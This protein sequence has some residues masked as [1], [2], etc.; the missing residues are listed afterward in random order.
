MQLRSS[1]APAAILALLAWAH[2][3]I[4]ATSN[5][6]ARPSFH[7]S[8]TGSGRPMILI[9]GLASSGETYNGV[10]AHYAGHYECHVLTLAGFAGE[11]RIEAPFLE[12]VR[13]DLARYIRDSHLDKPVIVGHSLGGF[14]AL[15]L[16]ETYPDLT[17]P[18]I[19][20][21]SLPFLP[22]VFQQG[23]T[24]ENVRPQAEMM[25]KAMTTGSEQ[26]RRKSSEMA[27]RSM[28]TSDANYQMVLGWGL[29]SDPVAVGNAMYDLFVHDLRTDT[30][31]V[32]SPVLVIGTWI[33]LKDY[34]TRDAVEKNFHAQYAGVKD[35]RFVMAEKARHFVM[36]DDPEWFLQQTDSFLEA[37]K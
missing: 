1:F 30:A 25:R 15:W 33:G 36:L 9:P 3:L 32:T 13:D 27:I 21:D 14:L 29:Q 2:P 28:V 18:V 8:V 16:A 11:P 37:H 23:A 4:A 6:P 31:R 34:T 7:V 5:E 17:G 24:A 35:F 20:V 19:I 12:T 26:D 22:A 10:V